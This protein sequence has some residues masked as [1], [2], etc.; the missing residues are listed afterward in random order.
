VIELREV[1]DWGNPSQFKS[2]LVSYLLYQ[3][4]ISLIRFNWRACT[5]EDARAYIGWS[6]LAG[7]EGLA[8]R[9][10]QLGFK[11]RRFLGLMQGA[12]FFRQIF[13]R[14]LQPVRGRTG[15]LR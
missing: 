13:A 12:K 10:G 15:L 8:V 7:V 5:G 6:L 2:R 14:V 4:V 3:R 1:T 11:L 9:G